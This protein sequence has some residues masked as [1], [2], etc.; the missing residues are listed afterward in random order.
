MTIDPITYKRLDQVLC[1]LG[2][3]RKRVEPKWLRYEHADSDTVIVLVEK[4]PTDFVRITDAVSA[5]R[6]LVERGLISAAEIDA[7]LHRQATR[8]QH[9][10]GKRG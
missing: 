3:L 10:S 8:K 1:Q 9:S 2:F 6:H 5:R 4:K 7:I